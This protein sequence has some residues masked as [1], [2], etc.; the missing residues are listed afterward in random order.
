[1][2]PRFGSPC[3]RPAGSRRRDTRMLASRALLLL[4]TSQ[5]FMCDLR[6]SAASV[7]S[8]L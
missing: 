5:L 4:L 3:P 8:Q 7:L 1:L 6:W 2:S